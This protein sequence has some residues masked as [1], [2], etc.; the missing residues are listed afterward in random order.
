MDGE[1]ER[2]SPSERGWQ[3][4]C[5]RTEEKAKGGM[6]VIRVGWLRRRGFPNCAVSLSVIDRF[7]GTINTRHQALA[8]LPAVFSLLLSLPCIVHPRQ[9]NHPRMYSSLATS[10]L[11]IPVVAAE[12]PSSTVCRSSLCLSHRYLPH[13]SSSEPSEGWKTLTF[14]RA[15]EGEHG[16]SFHP[17]TF[18]L[19]LFLGI[20]LPVR[21]IPL[22]H[23][24]HLL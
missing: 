16:A 10:P 4:H 15:S 23:P 21:F 22:P 5:G 24:F 6:R 9:T 13:R 7:A 8:T 19:S 18:S 20:P 17:L 14:K 11:F 1:I 2:P 12:S 3:K